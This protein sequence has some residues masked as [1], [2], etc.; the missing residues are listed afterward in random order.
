MENKKVGYLI[1][2]MAIVIGI[3]VFL[4]NTALKQIV[5]TSCSH[6]TTCPMYRDIRTQTVIS[7][8]LV[9]II[10]IIGLL[11]VFS[12]ERERIIVRTKK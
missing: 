9:A 3:I 11:L 10:I 7:L 1:I 6:G 2:G 8:V 5:S 4:F 12:K